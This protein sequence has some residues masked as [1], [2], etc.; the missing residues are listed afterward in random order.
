MEKPS[1]I[2]QKG[3]LDSYTI[4]AI[5][6]I[7]MTIDHIGAYAFEVPVVAA[8]Y[9]VFRLLG[10]IAAP[11]FLYMITES[12]R[13]THSRFK[14]ILRLY[15]S[16]VSF[17]IITALMNSFF[18]DVLGVYTHGNILYTYFF[19]VVYITL[20]ENLIS[21]I[22]TT[23]WKASL[24]AFIVILSTFL[25]HPLWSLVHSMRISSVLI[26]E[27]LESFVHSPFLVEY[28]PLFV[29]LGILMYFARNKWIQIGIFIAYCNI[30]YSSE[31]SALFWSTPLSV[32]LG[33]PQYWMVLA[34]PIMAL[35]NGH[36]GKEN[37]AL[38]Y[39]YYPI[40]IYAIIIITKLIG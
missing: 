33:Y 22:K 37:K 11:L 14:L 8:H 21:A 4:K 31:I 23:N 7:F 38:F 32:F 10:R 26:K 36:R 27:L 2:A 39:A 25:L 15:L 17:D 5:A 35:Y 9:S 18:G 3:L 13:Y 12:A 6:L 30:C 34:A 28:S 24:I 40:H 1:K 29:L 19:A 16:S 20:I